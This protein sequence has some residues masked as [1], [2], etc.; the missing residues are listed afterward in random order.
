MAHATRLSPAVVDA[1]VDA[2]VVVVVVVVNVVALVDGGKGRALRSDV[3]KLSK[4]VNSGASSPG[5]LLHSFKQAEYVVG[6]GV[7]VV[8]VDEIVVVVVVEVVAVVRAR[9]FD[10]PLP[11]SARCFFSFTLRDS[12]VNRCRSNNASRLLHVDARETESNG[13]KKIRK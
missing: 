6:G 11:T 7:D 2:V 5:Q 13:T 3:T 12:D 10:T 9:L 1:V 4:A 8:V